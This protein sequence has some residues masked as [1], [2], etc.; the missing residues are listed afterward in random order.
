MPESKI[1]Y[2][3]LLEEVARVTALAPPLA[4]IDGFTSVVPGE[5]VVC[6]NDTIGQILSVDTQAARCML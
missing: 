3:I 1:H 6:E 4:V 2:P 5:I